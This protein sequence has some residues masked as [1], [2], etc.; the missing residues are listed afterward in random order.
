MQVRAKVDRAEERGK[1]CMQ[2]QGQLGGVRSLGTGIGEG[3][4][5]GLGGH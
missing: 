4:G 2:G 1:A 5:G 3:E